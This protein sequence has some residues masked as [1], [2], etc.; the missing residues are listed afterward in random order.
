VIGKDGEDGVDH[1][2]AD[3]GFQTICAANGA[4]ALALL[5]SGTRPAI[6]LLDLM[7]P[8]M[9]GI[10]FRKRPAA[11]PR[12]STIPVVIVSADRHVAETAREL[13]VDGFLRKPLT[14]SQLVAEVRRCSS[15]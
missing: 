11:D 10:E 8:V 6:I 14:P 2:L 9:D 1:I 4:E 13:G 5:E 3:E 7:M 12:I 15:I